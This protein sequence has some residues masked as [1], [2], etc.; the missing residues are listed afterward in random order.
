MHVEAEQSRWIFHFDADIFD[1]GIEDK[2]YDE[3]YDK[4][5]ELKKKYGEKNLAMKCTKQSGRQK[6]EVIYTPKRQLLDK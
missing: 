4:L 5:E 1:E 2:E 6:L 3:L